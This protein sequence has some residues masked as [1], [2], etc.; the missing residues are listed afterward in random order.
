MAPISTIFGRNR[1]RRPKLFFQKIRD[2]EKI[3]RQR[4]DRGERTTDER[5]NEKVYTRPFCYKSLRRVQNIKAHIYSN[6]AATVAQAT[7]RVPG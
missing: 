1:S 2:V 7:I 6:A 4:K 3:A 5:T